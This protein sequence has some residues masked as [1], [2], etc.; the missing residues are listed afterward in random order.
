MTPTKA[1][2]PAQTEAQLHAEILAAEAALAA[3]K[4]LLS[5]DGKEGLK[6][7]RRAERAEKAACSVVSI[8]GEVVTAEI[9][10]END[11]VEEGDTLYYIAVRVKAGAKFEPSKAGARYAFRDLRGMV[12]WTDLDGTTMLT[13]VSRL[14][15]FAKLKA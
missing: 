11:A 6:L 3:K 2:T 15:G 14:Y 13:E 4:A 1:V 12:E 7:K 10:A 9:A 5:K 8:S